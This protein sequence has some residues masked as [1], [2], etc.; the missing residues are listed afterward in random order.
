VGTGP[1]GPRVRATLRYPGDPR[2][3]LASRARTPEPVIVASTCVG[4]AR[5]AE[6][7]IDHA[8]IS[9]LNNHEI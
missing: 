1:G 2:L 3:G 6:I 9:N 4:T 5:K 7:I 8:V